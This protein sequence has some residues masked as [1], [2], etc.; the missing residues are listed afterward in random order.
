MKTGA[1]LSHQAIQLH[2]FHARNRASFYNLNVGKARRRD[3]KACF[4][5]QTVVKVKVKV[6]VKQSRYRPGVAQRVP[7]S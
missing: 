4:I 2:S 7:G 5:L 6:K 3:Y 1:T